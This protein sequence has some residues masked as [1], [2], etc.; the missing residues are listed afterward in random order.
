MKENYQFN[1]TKSFVD[2]GM[3][4]ITGAVGGITSALTGGMGGAIGTQIGLGGISSGI[5]SG[6]NV[7]QLDMN[8]KQQTQML[9]AQQTDMKNSISYHSYGSDYYMS[10]DSFKY[11][12]D[13]GLLMFEEEIG[14]DMKAKIYNKFFQYGYVQN[15]YVEAFGK[16][17]HE[18]LPKARFSYIEAEGMHQCLSA[19]HMPT[20][21]LRQIG[22]LFSQGV[23]I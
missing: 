10:L 8:Y 4:A 20:A 15:R 18:L 9:N 2:I 17:L 1:R 22:T 19:L 21:V 14:A 7:K 6:L 23:Q 5:G 16:K 12:G 11:L 13:S 3:G